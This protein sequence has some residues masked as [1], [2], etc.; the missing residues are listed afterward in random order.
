MHLDVVGKTA[1]TADF[2]TG[3]GDIGHDGNLAF[4]ANLVD[5]RLG[6]QFAGLLVIGCQERLVILLRTLGELRVDQNDGNTG[7]PGLLD[8]RH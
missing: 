5:Q 3:T 6:R 4:R 8:G 7:F 2:G 1:D